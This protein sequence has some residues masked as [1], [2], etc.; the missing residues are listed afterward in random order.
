MRT[1]RHSSLF[2]L[3]LCATVWVYGARDTTL[4]V[5]PSSGL[6]YTNYRVASVPW[7]IHVVRLDRTNSAFEIH[8]MHAGRSA[9]G[10][11]T[12]SEQMALVS[13][14]LGTPCAAVN[15]DFYQ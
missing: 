5:A 15:G 14:A 6:D 11:G 13:P 7:S 2:L 4:A 8:S 9:L 10:L 3:W 1:R 12:L